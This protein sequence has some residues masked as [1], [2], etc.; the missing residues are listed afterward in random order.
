MYAGPP[1]LFSN[2]NGFS[3]QENCEQDLILTFCRL[4]YRRSRER[5]G[6]NGRSTLHHNRIQQLEIQP[7]HDYEQKNI[8]LT[9]SP[10]SL[11]QCCNDL[12]GKRKPHR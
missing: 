4:Y 7:I 12:R 6:A 8:H 9:P 5:N 2:R 10:V 1:S 3:S 11:L